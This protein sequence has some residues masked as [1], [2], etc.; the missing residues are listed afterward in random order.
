MKK[1]IIFFT[2]IFIFFITSFEFY[3]LEISAF[4]QPQQAGK[5]KHEA[6]SLLGKKLFATPVASDELYKLEAELRKTWEKYEA[7]QT[8]LENILEYGR[9]LA[10][11]WRYKA[12]I[13]M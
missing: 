8:N 5:R 13:G 1:R 2:L 6:I 7:D 10:S 3:P 9:H 11:L 12:A 4:A